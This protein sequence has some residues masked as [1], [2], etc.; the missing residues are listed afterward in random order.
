[1]ITTDKKE[2]DINGYEKRFDVP[3]TKIGVFP[4]LGRSISPELEPD[5]IYMVLRPREELTREETLKS[6]EGIPF[7]DEHTMIGEG[8]T[9]P[10]DKGIHGVTGNNVKVK[11]DLITND[12]TTY[13]QKLK[14]LIDIKNLNLYNKVYL[15]S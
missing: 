14:E 12:L 4:Y 7:V 8:F 9:P 2:T 11:G 5:K 10:E 6:L 3:M 15:R 1:M 13:S